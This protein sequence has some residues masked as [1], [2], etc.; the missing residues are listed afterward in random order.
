M[1]YHLQLFLMSAKLLNEINDLCLR[2]GRRFNIFDLWLRPLPLGTQRK[3]FLAFFEAIDK[4]LID[5]RRSDA[6][7]FALIDIQLTGNDATMTPWNGAGRSNSLLLQ[8]RYADPPWATTTWLVEIDIDF[9]LTNHWS[10]IPS[11]PRVHRFSAFRVM[12]A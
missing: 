9:S 8:F 12:C 5:I 4:V 3:D 1:L 2:L 11:N 7:H 6:G 10:K